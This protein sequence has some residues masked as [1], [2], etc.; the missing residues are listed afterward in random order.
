MLC[1]HRQFEDQ[2]SW[3]ATWLGYLL[4]YVSR[5]GNPENL[6]VQRCGRP[7]NED[8]VSVVL[9]A[10]QP[11]TRTAP[12]AWWPVGEALVDRLVAA[13]AAAVLPLASDTLNWRLLQVVTGRGLALAQ[14]VCTC[15]CTL[16]RSAQQAAGN[17]RRSLAPDRGCSWP[18]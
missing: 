16:W 8:I 6:R 11:G 2:H 14:A 17:G 3:V 1:L 5:G 7:G 13:V 9:R 18:C 4:L 10:L 12:P 15:V